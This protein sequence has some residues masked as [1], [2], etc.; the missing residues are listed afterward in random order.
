MKYGKVSTKLLFVCPCVCVHSFSGSINLV[1][2]KRVSAWPRTCWLGTRLLASKPQGATFFHLPNAGI[3]CAC[4]HAW[5]LLY[6]FLE[7]NSGPHTYIASTLQTELSHQP[8]N[9]NLLFFAKLKVF[10][11][12]KTPG[13]FSS[14]ASL[15][16]PCSELYSR[17]SGNLRKAKQEKGFIPK[18]INWQAGSKPHM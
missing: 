14:L 15:C 8:P 1:F 12:P 9:S 17:S 7:L 5:L 18:A 10:G 13:T 11:S 6:V 2:W 16:L 4:H 3:T